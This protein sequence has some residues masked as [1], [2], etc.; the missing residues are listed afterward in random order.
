MHNIIRVNKKL[1][2]CIKFNSKT[3]LS[4][5]IYKSIDL[6]NVITTYLVLSTNKI[7]HMYI[8]VRTYVHSVEKS[9]VHLIMKKIHIESPMTMNFNIK[10]IGALKQSDK[11][12]GQ[13]IYVSGNCHCKSD[14]TVNEN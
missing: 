14:K 11:L 9:Y 8:Y 13:F 7:I 10:S 1:E 6:T 5:L 3:L 2:L 12:F 4:L